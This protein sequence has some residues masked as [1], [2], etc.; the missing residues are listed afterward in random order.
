MEVLV[1]ADQK[2]V[3]YYSNEDLNNYILTVM[4]M[5]SSVPNSPKSGISTAMSHTV[6]A[7]QANL[8]VLSCQLPFQILW[9]VRCQVALTGIMLCKWDDKLDKCQINHHVWYHVQCSAKNHDNN[10]TSSTSKPVQTMLVL[11]FGNIISTF[12]K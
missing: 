1:V 2:M 3:E 5:A 6:D 12:I 10:V 8:L 11:I 9:Q 4:N 7:Y